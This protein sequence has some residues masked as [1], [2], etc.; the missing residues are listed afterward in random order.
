LEDSIL[1]RK[2]SA[3]SR[4]LYTPG[5]LNRLVD[6]ILHPLARHNPSLMLLDGLI[7][8]VIEKNPK[9]SVVKFVQYDLPKVVEAYQKSTAK[10]TQVHLVR[11]KRS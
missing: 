10:T 3:A 7:H 5:E 8:S 2:N 11:A 1:T 9:Q 4:Q 6:A